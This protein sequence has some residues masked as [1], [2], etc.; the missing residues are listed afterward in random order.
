MLLVLQSPAELDVPQILA[1]YREDSLEN[2]QEMFLA[3]TIA[4]SLEQR[5]AA[6][7]F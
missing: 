7:A 5:L 6:A 3:E 2:C 4:A 1:I